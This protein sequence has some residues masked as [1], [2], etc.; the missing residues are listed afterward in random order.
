MSEPEAVEVGSEVVKEDAAAE[1]D[2][3]NNSDF[4]VA[5]AD[6]SEPKDVEE[7]VVGEAIEEEP[8]ATEDAG[9]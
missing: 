1:A 8:K 3:K 5:A 2:P 6:E 9:V 7:E 4:V